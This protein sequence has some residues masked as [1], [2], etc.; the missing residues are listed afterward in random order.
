MSP[1]A[2]CMALASGPAGPVLVGLVFKVIF[3]TAHADK[4]HTYKILGSNAF[5][6]VVHAHVRSYTKL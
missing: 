2:M 6:D 3:A 4:Y 1:I 5:P